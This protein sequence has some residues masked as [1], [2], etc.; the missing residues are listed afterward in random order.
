MDPDTI[1]SEQERQTREHIVT[2]RFHRRLA[3]SMTPIHRTGRIIL[4]RLTRSYRQVEERLSRLSSLPGSMTQGRASEEASDDRIRE[5]IEEAQAYLRA[6]R[7]AE[8]ER[9]FLEVLK[10]DERQIDAYRGLAV[11]YLAQKQFPQAKETFL[12]IERIHGADDGCYAGLAEIAEAEGQ[13][14]RAEVMRKRAVEAAPKKAARH[15]ELAS[16]YLAHGSPDFALAEARRAVA[17]EPD[18]LRSLEICLEAAILVRDRTEAERCLD[19]L[20]FLTE[21][22]SKIQAYREKI[23]AFPR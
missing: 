6:A 4:D 20:R 19:R 15:A 9:T 22:R 23:D 2:Q 11:L 18:V 17:L 8:A 3:N 12:F 5:R 7:W 14:T 10:L 21:D 13:T 16:F 1:R